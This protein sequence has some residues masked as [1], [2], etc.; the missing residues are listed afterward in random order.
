MSPSGDDENL[1]DTEGGAVKSGHVSLLR[2]R[3]SR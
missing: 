1:P 2:R 3:L